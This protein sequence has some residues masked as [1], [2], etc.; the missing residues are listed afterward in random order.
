MVND[1]VDRRKDRRAFFS[2]EDNILG[3]FILHGETDLAFKAPILNLSRGGLHFTFKKGL[4]ILPKAG[5][6]LRLVKVK[7]DTA[8][9]FEFNIEVGIKWI[10]GH[11][12]LTQIGCGCEFID[13]SKP[14]LERIS[15]FI[16]SKYVGKTF[17]GG[18]A[19]KR[20]KLKHAGIGRHFTSLFP[21]FIGL[22]GANSGNTILNSSFGWGD[23]D[24]FAVLRYGD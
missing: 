10:L 5:D 17:Q 23:R 8:L 4:G 3:I 20:L 24:G 1:G 21:F 2:I 6:R 12:S 14:C 16:D 13:I 19:D 18:G 22:A 15:A 9:D 7:G 11:E